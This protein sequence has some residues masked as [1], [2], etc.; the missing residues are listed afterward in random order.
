MQPTVIGLLAA[1]RSNL[2]TRAD[3]E[4][5]IL[6]LRHHGVFGSHRLRNRQPTCARSQST[7]GLTSAIARLMRATAVPVASAFA[8]NVF[9]AWIS[10]IRKRSAR[11][12]SPRYPRGTE[13]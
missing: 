2:R 7:S 9:P 8:G 13:A 12:W 1:L 6:A 4:A 3:L 5:G 11:G 10:F